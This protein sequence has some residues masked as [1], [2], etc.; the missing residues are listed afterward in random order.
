[1]SL[2]L[3]ILYNP[4]KM[5]YITAHEGV[6]IRRNDIGIKWFAALVKCIHWFNPLVYYL[7]RQINEACEISCDAQAVEHMC[8]QQRREYMQTILEVSQNEI[9]FKGSL[10]A[11]LSSGGR[12]LKKRFLAINKVDKKRPL[13]CAT[14]VVA[15]M[16]ITFCSVYTCGIIIGSAQKDSQAVERI[17]VAPKN[18][19][20]EREEKNDVSN[21]EENK[22]LVEDYAVPEMKPLDTQ[23][24]EEPKTEVVKKTVIT[25]EFNSEGGDTRLIPDIKPDESGCIS[26]DIHS[27]AQEV[28]DVFVNDGESGR[29]VHSFSIPV[30]HSASYV[31]DGLDR[32][33][34]YD[35]VL[36][37]TMRNNWKIESEYIIY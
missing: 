19:L 30:S 37:G 4:D 20:P 12:C 29:E 27:N 28:I 16:L 1:M 13:I 36:R 9:N 33:R 3:M 5:Q 18:T 31:I 32:N 10:S 11:G 26:L 22:G 34:V 14:G 17:L 25:G 2:D 21:E 24:T 15:A 8:D 6:H 35:I 7:V 23:P